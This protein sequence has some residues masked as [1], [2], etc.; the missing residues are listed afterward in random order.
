MSKNKSEDIL[1][2]AAFVNDSFQLKVPFKVLWSEDL[3]RAK[4]PITRKNI[5]FPW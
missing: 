5:A 2:T 3:M 1:R 4:Q